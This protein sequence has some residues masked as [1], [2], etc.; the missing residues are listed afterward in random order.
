[1]TVKELYV[2]SGSSGDWELRNKIEQTVM[3]NYKVR[4]NDQITDDVANHIANAWKEN[5]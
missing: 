2:A 1:M 3:R 5:K 4:W